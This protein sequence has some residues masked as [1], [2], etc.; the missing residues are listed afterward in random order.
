MPAGDVAFRADGEQK[1]VHRCNGCGIERRNRVAADDNPV[2]LLRV[3]PLPPTNRES[4]EE[5]EA[6]AWS[7]T[8]GAADAF[9]GDSGRSRAIGPT[10]GNRMRTRLVWEEGTA[11]TSQALTRLP[12]TGGS[13]TSTPRNGRG[14]TRQSHLRLVPRAYPAIRMRPVAASGGEARNH[15]PPRD[16]TYTLYEHPQRCQPPRFRPGHATIRR[17]PAGGAVVASNLLSPVGGSRGDQCRLPTGVLGPLVWTR[18]CLRPPALLPWNRCRGA[19][20]FLAVRRSG[21]GSR[22]AVVHR[23]SNSRRRETGTGGRASCS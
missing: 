9:I 22:G 17:G 12:V 7:N 21:C 5:E 14:S 16:C 3:P 8:A 6:I 2:D 15:R 1:L 11:P 23:A 18:F 10:R 20:V 4:G 13:A 19:A